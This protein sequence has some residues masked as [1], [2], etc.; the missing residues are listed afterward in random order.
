MKNLSKGNEMKT[1]NLFAEVNPYK[2][3][4]YQHKGIIKKLREIW[5]I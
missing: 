5:Y 3:N 1:W 4:L 2:L